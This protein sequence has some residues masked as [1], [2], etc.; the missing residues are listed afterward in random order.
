MIPLPLLVQ[1][2]RPK[3]ISKRTEA[4]LVALLTAAAARGSWL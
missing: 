3:R 2:I 1:V 4:W